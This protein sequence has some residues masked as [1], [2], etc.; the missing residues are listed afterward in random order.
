M[1]FIN[2]IVCGSD[3]SVIGKPNNVIRKIKCKICGIVESSH[4]KN[5]HPEVVI[6][7]NYSENKFTEEEELKNENF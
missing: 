4:K 1:S 6:I 3:A 5:K 2:C 7:P